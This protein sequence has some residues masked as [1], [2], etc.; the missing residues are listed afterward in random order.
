[1]LNTQ[2]HSDKPYNAARSDIKTHIRSSL[3]GT[4]D[5]NISVGGEQ[6]QVTRGNVRSGNGL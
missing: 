1:M 2:S 6:F 4:T 3:K 5:D